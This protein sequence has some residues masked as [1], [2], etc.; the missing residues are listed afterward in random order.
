MHYITASVPLNFTH[1]VNR[2]AIINTEEAKTI[3]A[4]TKKAM[5]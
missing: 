3:L 2:L 4:A 5:Q 1:P